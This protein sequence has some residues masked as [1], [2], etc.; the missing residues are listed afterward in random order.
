MPGRDRLFIHVMALALDVDFS[1]HLFDFN[2]YRPD[3]FALDY[4]GN[5]EPPGRELPAPGLAEEARREPLPHYTPPAGFK[6]AC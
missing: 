2:S 4:S 5:T 1:N 3:R 6:S